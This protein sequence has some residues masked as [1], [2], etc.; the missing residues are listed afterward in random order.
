[1]N[2]LIKRYKETKNQDL[3]EEILNKNKG[4]IYK[5][6][7]KYKETS[8]YSYDDMH[9]ICMLS[10]IKAIETYD[11]TKNMKFSTYFYKIMNGDLIVE[12]CVNQN[13]KK[14]KADLVSFDY[15]KINKNGEGQTIKHTIAD[16]I[17]V[18]DIVV[19]KITRE[20]LKKCLME[21]KNEY[22]KKYMAVELTLKGYS[23]RQCEELLP[24]GKTTVSN[25][26]KHFCN[27]I[28]EKAI[29]EGILNK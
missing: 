24:Y 20:F 22:K 14:R 28:R 17:N 18:E 29:T 4:L 26:W 21:Y 16:K 15:K 25:N 7:S 10:L 5:M 6:V 27:Y 11:E 23:N 13:R 12:L 3:F 8:L 2:E 19:D 1:M 9:Q